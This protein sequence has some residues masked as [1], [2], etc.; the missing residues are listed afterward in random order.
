MR[1]IIKKKSR[2][3]ALAIIGLAVAL[4]VLVLIVAWSVPLGDF[5]AV[6]PVPAL[7]AG[8]SPL[9]PI[10]QT[11]KHTC[12]LLA[13]SS[14]YRS[15]GI[16]PDERRLR[17]RLGVDRPSILFDTSSTGCIQ[18]DIYRVLGQ[19]GFTYVNIP[20][21]DASTTVKLQSHL[22]AG[23]PALAL[24]RRR[25]TG[26]LHWLVLSGLT[27]GQVT[28][29]DS[30]QHDPYAES[31]PALQRECLIEI[32]FVSPSQLDAKNYSVAHHHYQGMKAM[33]ASYTK[34]KALPAR[35]PLPNET[36]TAPTSH[37]RTIDP[38]GVAATR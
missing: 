10:F 3:I 7:V 16:S 28:L 38:P 8:Q 27:G 20:V 1:K 17:A 19:D 24:I 14:I 12:G 11:E 23:N 31:W 35:A 2:R 9:T 26:N 6:T 33:Y 34:M 18:P 32:L 37:T 29:Y 25:E 15:Y 5:A 21:N 36:A 30:L 22:S 13:L 4:W